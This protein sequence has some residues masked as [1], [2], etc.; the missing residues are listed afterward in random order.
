MRG[1]RRRGN[2]RG[3]SAIRRPTRPDERQADGV[4]TARGF[5]TVWILV[6]GRRDADA[7]KA[8][9]RLAVETSL[10]TAIDGL[11]KGVTVTSEPRP[12]KL[13]AGPPINFAYVAGPNGARIE[14]VERPGLKPGE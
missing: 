1:A 8:I 10:T 7:G 2:V 14:L 13:P 3:C 9:D 6:E 11:E 12:L 5:S 4:A